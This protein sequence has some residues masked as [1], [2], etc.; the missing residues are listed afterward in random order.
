MKIGKFV[1]G[2]AIAAVVGLG[3]GASPSVSADVACARECRVQYNSCLAS[4]STGGC[5][6]VCFYNY[7]N[8]IDGC[9]I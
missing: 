6:A 2:A 4:C 1:F 9:S 5:R 8:C 3:I 7:E